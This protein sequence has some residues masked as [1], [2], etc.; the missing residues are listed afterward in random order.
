MAR[1]YRGGAACYRCRA[2]WVRGSARDFPIPGQQHLHCLFPGLNLPESPNIVWYQPVE[3]VGRAHRQHK[4]AAEDDS[5]GYA[6]M[7]RL[8]EAGNRRAPPRLQETPLFGM[9]YPTPSQ[10]SM[11]KVCKPPITKMSMPLDQGELVARKAVEALPMKLQ[12]GNRAAFLAHARLAEGLVSLELLLVLFA[13]HDVA[14][15]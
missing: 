10:A 14:L 9:P 7:G 2:A 5:D 11:R 1:E 3:F 15:R 13:L 12:I 8:E 4:A 6:H